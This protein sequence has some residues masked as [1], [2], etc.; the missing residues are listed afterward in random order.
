MYMS[1]D[2][3]DLSILQLSDSFFPSGTY[4]MSN[5]LEMFYLKKS[6]RGANDVKSLIQIFLEQQVGPADCVAASNAYDC[7]QAKDMAGVITID[8]TIFRMRLVR[9]IRE[10]SIRSGRQL[11]KSVLSFNKDSFLVQYH[12]KITQL[13]AHGTYPV[14]FSVASNVLGISKRSCCLGM[15]YGFTVSM[16]G[17]ALRLGIIQHME[18]QKIINSLKP[19]ISKTVSDY[20]G[21]NYHQIWQFTPQADLYQMQHEKIDAK[22]FV[23]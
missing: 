3:S 18:G 7:A 10:A 21:K 14:A 8:E 16:V 6:L 1:T 22:M 5:G 15:C 19:I 2:F 4:T 13:N 12:D 9:E 23:T 17:A 20:I 11:V